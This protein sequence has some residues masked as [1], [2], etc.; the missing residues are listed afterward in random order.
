[1]RRFPYLSV[2]NEAFA[3]V[4]AFVYF[5]AS[6]RGGYFAPVIAVIAALAFVVGVASAVY[7]GW[8]GE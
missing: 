8:R 7:R 4:W 6:G 3:I 1:M 2:I 5:E